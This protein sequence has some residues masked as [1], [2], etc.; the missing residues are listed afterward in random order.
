MHLY[1]P[2]LGLAKQYVEEA[3]QPRIQMPAMPVGDPWPAIGIL[4][5]AER[6]IRTQEVVDASNLALDPYWADLVRLLQVFACGHDA[7]RIDALKAT[8]AWNRY[9]SYIEDRA[10]CVRPG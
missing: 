1:E 6:R 4:L 7:D 8:M 2:E 3:V 5:D 10:K 9:G